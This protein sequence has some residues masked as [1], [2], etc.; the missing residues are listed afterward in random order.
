MGIYIDKNTK[1]TKED[2]MQSV[3]FKHNDVEFKIIKY[4]IADG[5]CS[6]DKE[7][8]QFVTTDLTYEFD[9]LCG[10]ICYK[11]YDIALSNKDGMDSLD[12]EEAIGFIKDEFIDEFD[13]MT[14]EVKKN[15]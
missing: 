13:Y 15:V 14:G 1:I 10:G 9:V 2:F 7:K 12:M 3:S 6:F 8:L 4:T 5:D 11:I